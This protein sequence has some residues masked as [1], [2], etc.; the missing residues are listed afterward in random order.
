MDIE[1]T[2]SQPASSSLE[3]PD[4]VVIGEKF[5]KIRKTYKSFV[6]RK[7]ITTYN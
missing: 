5:S 3:W 7:A 2:A 6:Q 1:D 4:Y